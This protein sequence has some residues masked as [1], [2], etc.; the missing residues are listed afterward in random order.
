M[1]SSGY[2]EGKDLFC[3]FDRALAAEE[4]DNPVIV[5]QIFFD[6]FYRF[7]VVVYGKNRLFARPRLLLSSG[8]RVLPCLITEY[9]SLD[10]FA[11][12]AE[13]NLFRICCKLHPCTMGSED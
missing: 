5:S 8:E 2:C 13:V 6:Y 3:F 11:S 7:R 12:L 1:I 9:E 4:T 10:E